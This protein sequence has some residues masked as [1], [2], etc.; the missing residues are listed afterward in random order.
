M[1]IINSWSITS[2]YEGRGQKGD[3][4][5]IYRDSDGK[6]KVSFE[7]FQWYFF[8]DKTDDNE[9]IISKLLKGKFINGYSKGNGYFKIDVDK[10]EYKDKKVF[11]VVKWFHDKGIKTYEADV[12]PSKRMLLDKRYKI[13]DFE[14]VNMMYLDIET[15]DSSGM[16]EYEEWRGKKSIKAKDQI[17]SIC[18]MD[19]TGKE[20][21]FSDKE[22][23]KILLAFSDF[24][25]EKGVDMLVGWN[26]KEFDLPYITKRMLKHELPTFYIKNILH[27]DMMRR[28]QYFYSKDPEARQNITSYSL[29]SISQYFL[30]EGKTKFEGSYLK[31]W[32]DDPIKFK[33][34]NIQDCR[35]LKKLEDKIGLI[36]LTY[37]MSQMC[38]CTAQN[39]A[40]IKNLD[41]F[42]LTEANN[43]G[44]HYPTN[45]TY[46][47]EDNEGEEETAPEEYLGAFV[48]T[49]VPGAY[50]NV[51]DLDFKSLYPNI[52][53]TFNISPETYCEESVSW[54]VAT[55]GIE[56]DGVMR[57]KAYFRSTEGIIPRKIGLLLA[58]REKI[59][60][61]QKGLDK[62]SR[63]WKDLNVK[64]LVVKEL[65]NSI[66]GVIGNQYFRGFNVNMAESITAT[67]Q[68]L[69]KHLTEIFNAKGR[70]VIYGDTD[71]LFVILAE[72][73]DIEEVLKETNKYIK[74][75]LEEEY[76]VR[77]C[78]IQM[79]LDKKFDKFFIEA[80]KKYI[81][82]IRGKLNFVGMECVKRDCIPL[83]AKVQRDL[84]KKIFNKDS[85]EV[86]SNWIMKHK[87]N[88]IEAKIDI[89]E[90]T[91]Y[92]KITRNEYK[93]KKDSTKKYTA[94]IHVRIAYELKKESNG[95]KDFTSAGTIL[96][97]IIT[98]GKGGLKGIHLGEYKGEFDKEYYWDN[99]IYPPLERMLK[100]VYKDH[101]WKQ[102]YIGDLKRGIRKSAK[103]KTPPRSS[104]RK[105]KEEPPTT[106]QKED[107]V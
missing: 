18:L 91:I 1:K 71:S 33:E 95:K 25:F 5:L 84:I 23:R 86:I 83:A 55:P 70:K 52:I 13:E 51:Y 101:D 81:G 10:K 88:L 72:G 14:N 7:K 20:Y 79:A 80:K 67:G 74:K 60:E 75:H 42:I 12:G 9:K 17:L 106:T 22:E 32:K 61:K 69:I 39:W 36:A 73:E 65:A 77:E 68:Y 29:E 27:E 38:G 78:T 104:K 45:P 62:E 43:K 49:P 40:M 94:P 41:N 57:G 87:A 103:A 21:Y 59:R 82:D 2:D 54:T 24:L 97:Y 93:P 98:E 11:E 4:V 30:K 56:K 3:V 92:K 76:R 46:L 64:Q 66:Y 90:I 48:L 50:E 8:V 63:E 96:P 58:E 47:R 19:R 100:H 89:E 16:I 28:V 105:K 44:I 15:D 34:Y 26:S 31:L 102:Y 6:R 35:L 37:H 99:L 107:A 53:R 85:P